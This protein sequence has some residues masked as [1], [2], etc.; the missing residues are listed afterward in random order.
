MKYFQL[1]IYHNDSYLLEVSAIDRHKYITC[2][3]CELILNKRS[4]IEHYLLAYRIKRKRY[5]L[6]GSYDGFNV[7]SHKFKQLYKISN[8]Q[9]LI[10][11]P[12][13][14]NKGFYLVE[15][16]ETIVVEKNKRPILFEDQCQECGLYKG[17]YGSVPAYIDK[18]TIS[19]L[20]LN[21]FYRS[22]LEFGYDFEQGYYLLASQ[23]IA[24]ILIEHK[25]IAEKDLI[26][27]HIV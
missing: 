10:F 9:G 20:R 2:P 18:E 13:H 27:I 26:E 6:S 15:C 5:H 11:Y 16:V 19:H 8:W 7:V 12:I 25:L 4:L 22:D 21:T 1:D 23:E 14:R 17:V 24:S 3:T